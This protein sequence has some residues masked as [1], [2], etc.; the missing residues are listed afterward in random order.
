MILSS[1]KIDHE[2]V[3]V[4]ASEEAKARMRQ[5][6]DDPR[7]LPPQIC[8]GDQYCGVS[9]FPLCL[10]YIHNACPPPPP[11]R[12]LKLLSMP[13]RRSAS[14]S[15]SRSSELQQLPQHQSKY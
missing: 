1:K 10:C 12:T 15:S 9:L 11:P 14:R 3:D 6:V 5:I 13:L 2:N 8:N 7:A 4:A